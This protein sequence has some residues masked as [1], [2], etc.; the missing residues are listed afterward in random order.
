MT[1]KEYTVDFGDGKTTMK[2]TPVNLS[3]YVWMEKFVYIKCPVCGKVAVIDIG[4]ILTSMPPK[5]Q[6]HCKHCNGYGYLLC[7]ETDKFEHITPTKEDKDLYDP[8]ITFSQ[9]SI[10][11]NGDG[12]IESSKSTF[13]YPGP[14]SIEGAINE[15][16]KIVPQEIKAYAKCEICGETF[17]IPTTYTSLYNSVHEMPRHICKDCAEKLRKLIGK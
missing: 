16:V 17:E 5:Y 8:P 15:P 3:N 11:I 4:K 7:G 13:T 9:E 2:V 6:W 12:V 14:V 1:D 10:S